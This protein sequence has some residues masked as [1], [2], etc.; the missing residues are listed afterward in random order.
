MGVSNIDR[1][2]TSDI[3]VFTQLP[4]MEI[5]RYST[6]NAVTQSKNGIMIIRFLHG[7]ATYTLT[8]PESFQ[9]QCDFVSFQLKQKNTSITSKL[10]E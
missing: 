8:L 2:D 4:L 1:L 3:D 7:T 9:L 6:L 5:Q 10:N